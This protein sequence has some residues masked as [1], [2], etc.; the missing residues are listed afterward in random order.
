MFK[1]I[2]GSSAE[3]EF[4]FSRSYLDD[5]IW[6]YIESKSNL[7]ISAPRRVGKTSFM[8][9]MATTGKD[10][11]QVKYHI[12]E[13]I[14]SS[15]EFFKRLCKSILEELAGKEGVWESLNEFFKRTGIQKIGLDGIEFKGVDIDYFEEFRRLT[16]KVDFGLK[17]VFI[18]D[19]FSETVEN[20][21]TDHGE[22]EAKRFLHQNRELRQDSRIAEKILFIYSGSI[23]LGNITERIGAIK[24]INDLADFV[25]PPLSEDESLEMITQLTI[26]PKVVFEEDSRRY[27]LRSLNWL[28]PY[29]VQIV[30]DELDTLL[31]ML[32]AVEV[33]NELI[34]RAID[35]AL[36]KRTYFEHWHSRLRMALTGNDYS[37]AKEVLNQ[38]SKSEGGLSYAKVVDLA[39]RLDL[40]ESYQMTLRTLEYDGYIN[41]DKSRIYIFNSPLLKEWW[42]RNIAI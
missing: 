32:G 7:L 13:S 17:L 29:Y 8:K 9:N 23:G 14:N 11:Y 33:T 40:R 6:K 16:S 19:E 26:D 41:K 25:I 5:R 27:L 38:V 36:N 24:T 34:D 30:L 31:K 39:E 1:T 22:S 42:K 35:E 12:T 37:F 4:Y 20:I 18:I 10:G 3:G 28:M 21:I 2:V 15:N